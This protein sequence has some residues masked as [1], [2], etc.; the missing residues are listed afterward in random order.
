M[1]QDRRNFVKLTGLAALGSLTGV[2]S[3]GGTESDDSDDQD[4]SD[5]NVNIDSGSGDDLPLPV[6]TDEPS[7]SAQALLD[8]LAE[9]D[10]PFINELSAE[11]AR[12]GYNDFFIEDREPQSVGDVENREIPGP[13]E[14]I[15]IRIYTPEDSSFDDPLP[16]SV[17]LHG[18]GW[19]LGNLDTHDSVARSLTNASE[20]IVVSVD[21][22]RGPEDRFP[23]AINDSYAAAQWVADN[24]AEIGADS[25]RLAVCGESAGGDMSA[26]IAQKAAVSGDFDLD[27]QLLIYPVTDLSG[28]WIGELP[29]TFSILAGDEQELDRRYL[30]PEDL[31]W[32]V[33]RYLPYPEAATN[34]LASPLLARDNRL[35]DTP[36]ATVVTTGF[37]PLGDQGYLYARNLAEAGVDVEVDHY[38]N[39][40]HDFFNME[41]LNDPYPD[42]PEAEVAKRRAG[43][44]LKAGFENADD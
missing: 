26:V 27:Y 19:V 1:S 8:A 2:A 36:P 15:P 30:V 37:G 14:D 7:E 44:A 32:F 33:E 12:A 10:F 43:E 6:R 13:E 34:L 22:R 28:S 11:E 39:L 21:Y 9:Q 24:A 29:D 35:E 16:V 40:I 18:G 41:F 23:A 20:A 42:I 5:V 31:T 17:Y 38:P 3:G 4:G 25:N